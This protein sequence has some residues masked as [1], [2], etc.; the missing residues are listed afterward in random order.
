VQARPVAPPCTQAMTVSAAVTPMT[1]GETIGCVKRLAALV[2]IVLVTVACTVGVLYGL[3]YRRH[4]GT[5]ER[6]RVVGM[7][8]E[9]AAL[10]SASGQQKQVTYGGAWELGPGRWLVRHNW[11]G[12]WA[13]SLL[14]VKRYRGTLGAGNSLDV[15]GLTR[16][17]DNDCKAAEQRAQ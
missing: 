16:V 11:P 12:G 4:T 8:R 9:I 7:G 6:E 1:A 14:D 3:G 10:I 5:S 2:L 13:C 15:T 17:G